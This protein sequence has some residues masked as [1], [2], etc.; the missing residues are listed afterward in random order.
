[1][2]HTVRIHSTTL[3]WDAKDQ[4]YLGEVSVRQMGLSPILRD[5]LGML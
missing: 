4:I 3:I 2:S 5:F 1:M